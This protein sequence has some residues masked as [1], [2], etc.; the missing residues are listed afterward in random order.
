VAEFTA[1]LR[2]VADGG[3]ALDPEVVRQL[4]ARGRAGGPVSRLTARERDVLSLI[5]E[6]HSNN[7]IAETLVVSVGA[8][9]KHVASILGKL[10]LPPDDRSHRRV[11]A[12]LSYLQDEK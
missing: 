8:V 7:S 11:L 2:R 1:S 12:V 6:G 9:E 3:T 4:L 10:E 5:A